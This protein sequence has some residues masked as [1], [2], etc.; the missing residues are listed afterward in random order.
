MLFLQGVCALFCCD[1]TT[2]Y[3]IVLYLF[4]ALVS[5]LEQVAGVQMPPNKLWF[6]RLFHLVLYFGCMCGCHLLVAMTVERFYSIIQPHKA[7]SFNTV[8]KARIIVSFIF[9]YGFIYS[10]PY[11]LIANYNGHV[12][13]PNAA[14]TDSVFGQMYSWLTETI[15]FIFPFLSLLIMNSV[16]IH[17]LRKRSKQKLLSKT[18]Q[19]GQKEGQQLKTKHQENQIITMLLLVTFAYLSLNIPV[20]ILVIYL[21]FSS[22]NTPHYY[23]G[24]Y[25]AYQVEEKIYKTNHAINIFLYVLSGKKFRTDLKNLFMSKKPKTNSSE[26]LSSNTRDST[27]SSYF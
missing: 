17:T 21:N 10:T 5:Y 23:A 15:L 16:I 3:S 11:L 25:L 1:S 2:Q 27:V 18:D 8:K 9:L 13:I 12:C 26:V 7:A 22:G 19:N 6:C 20:R 14:V 24:L 4:P